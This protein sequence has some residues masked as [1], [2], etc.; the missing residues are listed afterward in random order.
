MFYFAVTTLCEILTESVEA[1]TFGGMADG[2]SYGKLR[3]RTAAEYVQVAEDRLHRAVSLLA[4]A[5]RDDPA[6]IRLYASA[7]IERH[8]EW[9][10]KRTYS[11]AKEAK[12][13]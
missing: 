11:H 9:F 13:A 8:A 12:T 1:I 6:A 4:T 5:L 2:K 7:V 3:P 10:G